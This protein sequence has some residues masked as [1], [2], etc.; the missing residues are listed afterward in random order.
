MTAADAKE[1]NEAE[2][3]TVNRILAFMRQLLR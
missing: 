2:M 1:T 3:Q